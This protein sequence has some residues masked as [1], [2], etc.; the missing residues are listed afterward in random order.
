VFKQ[1]RNLHFWIILVADVC[2]FV[3][4]LVLSYVVRYSAAIPHA[5]FHAIQLVLP[6]VI[7]VK[8]LTF[9]HTGV[10]R[11]MWRYTSLPDAWRLLSSTLLTL[12]VITT[13]L[14]FVNRF[15]GYPR[16][17]F[18]AD[19]IFTLF[20]CGGIRVGIRLFYSTRL[21]IP[22]LTDQNN[23]PPPPRSRLILI[24]A[25]DAADKIIREVQGNFRS[26]YEIVCCLDDDTAKQ[27]RSMHG[28]PIRGPV[29]HLS[30]FAKKFH[31]AETLI[32]MPSV[33]GDR[34]REIVATCEASKIPFRTLPSL[35]ALIDGDVTI[36]DLRPVN[37][38]DLLGRPAVQ[39]DLAKIGSYL[40]GKTV[41]VTGAGGSIGSELCRQII[42]FNP[43]ALILIDASEYNLYKI[44][45]E[46]KSDRQFA[47][48][49]P[50]LGRVQDQPLLDHI[51][52]KYRPRVVFHAAAYKH[53]PMVELNPW[54]AI[55]NNVVGSEVVM[56]TAEK[57]GVE[58]F[59]LISSDKAVRP[60][61]VMG[62]SKRVAEILLQSRPQGKTRFM[63]VRFGNVVGSSGSVIPLFQSQIKAGGPVTITH[64]EMTRYFMTIPEAC[65]LL[66]QTGA[67]GNGGEI[68]VLEMGTPVKIAD[69]ARDLIRLSGK[70]PDRDIQ[71]IYTG[72]R[73]G[74]KLYEELITHGEGIVPTAH[75]KIMVLQREHLADTTARE[76]IRQEL[77]ELVFT[78]GS[79]D[80]S[81]IRTALQGIVADYA[82][83]SQDDTTT[84]SHPEKPVPVITGSRPSGIVLSPT[85]QPFEL[86]LVTTRS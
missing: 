64:P 80:A 62:A 22:G 30:H 18:I 9:A 25:G 67:L 29:S 23:L 56:Q 3:A 36:N 34:L 16:S 75:K 58:R 43:A 20:F 6:W 81:Q 4:A 32:V 61:N 2:L 24:G 33:T 12:L 54:E 74:E 31:A 7:L 51:F 37:F 17:V 46:L 27:Q 11:G 15:H 14:T 40:T 73:P 82:P 42:R 60:T 47:S 19:S 41:A 66:L 78:A 28:I 70:E 52:G 68:F 26:A 72:I 5:E 35:S 83:T 13:G 53:V 79:Y 63:A 10:Y 76:Y 38:E 48:V 65:Q 59:V 85:N 84:A 57:Y 1:F 45:L 49:V 44:E 71:I 55:H 21:Q 69:M 77:Q 39:L 8:V 50:I 86:E